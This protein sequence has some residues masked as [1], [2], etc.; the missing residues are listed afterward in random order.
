MEEFIKL[1]QLGNLENI[2]EYNEKNQCLFNHE[3]S[4]SPEFKIQLE[5]AVNPNPNDVTCLCKEFAFCNACCFGHTSVAKWLLSVKPEIDISVN[6]DA[7]FRVACQYGNLST[8][9]W[10]LSVKPDINISAGHDFAFRFACTNGHLET[11][12]WL[13]SVKPDIDISSKNEY[14]FRLACTNGY[15]EIAQWLLSIKPTIKILAK[16]NFVLQSEHTS[17]LKW[18]WTVNPL[19]FKSVLPINEKYVNMDTIDENEKLCLIC[20]ETNA[21]LQTNCEHNFC[22]ICLMHFAKFRKMKG[23]N[24]EFDDELDDCCCPYCRTK[25]T[26]CYIIS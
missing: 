1:C 20:Y 6:N 18:F 17:I 2:I 23:F 7:V 25:I 15:L 16:N 9:Q 14:A 26:T 5:C 3:C 21:K 4:Y 8:A 11:A 12:R 10:L 19:L 22:G 24:D 13:L